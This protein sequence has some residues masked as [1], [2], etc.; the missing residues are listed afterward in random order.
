MKQKI[1]NDY[2]PYI[3]SEAPA[4]V[5]RVAENI[6]FP[7]IVRFVA[8]E[9]DINIFVEEFKKIK[10]IDEFQGKFMSKAV[11]KVIETSIK[12]LTYSELKH[13]TKEKSYMFISNH[14]DI[15]LDSAILQVIFYNNRF[16]T[17]EITFGS[18]L[19]L[20]QVVID[21][22]KLNKMFKI[23]RGGSAREVFQNSLNVS[24]YMRYAITQK[25]ASTWIAQRNGRTKDGCDK[26]E[27]AVLKMFAM[28]SK[29]P[30]VE[31][32]AELN[33]APVAVSYEYEPCDFMKTREIYLTQKHGQYIK[34]T[35]EDLL[36]IMH[37]IK[38]YKGN[39]HFSFCKPI[40]REE[41]EE[42]AKFPYN[43]QFKH[44]ANIIDKRICNGY[45]LF[46]TNYIAH[47]LRESKTE[48]SKIYSEADKAEFTFYMEKGLK[49]IE[50]NKDKLREIFLGI[51]AN[52]IEAKQDVKKTGLLKS[53]DD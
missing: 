26:T 15:T 53:I 46:K 38:Q 31:N 33:I 16:K 34:Q 4:A 3:D 28:S 36:S 40:I 44:L 20:S 1:Y 14:R 13:L 7:E 35:G 6:Y 25:G 50:G 52:P 29:K 30:F 47:D 21:I 11:K 19:M 2:R 27:I 51:Y 37:G 22:G 41:L 12:K 48:F 23:V 39:A 5:Q 32:L 42:C 17:S 49:K 10:T 8:P 45:K 43:E 18:N 24:E 9:A